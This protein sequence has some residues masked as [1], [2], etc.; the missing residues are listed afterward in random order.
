LSFVATLCGTVTTRV[1]VLLCVFMLEI[2]AVAIF[3]EMGGAQDAR[4][5]ICN[6]ETARIACIPTG[7]LLY[8]IGVW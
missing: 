8:Q 3:M 1:D 5:S 7:V 4:V 6:V 2:D